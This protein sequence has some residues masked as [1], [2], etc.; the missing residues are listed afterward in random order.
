MTTTYF[1]NYQRRQM[2]DFLKTYFEIICTGNCLENK[3]EKFT[4]E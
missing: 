2:F 1:T 3:L 4:L